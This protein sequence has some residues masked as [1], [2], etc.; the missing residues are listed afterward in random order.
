MRAADG[1]ESVNFAVD[2]DRTRPA[3]QLLARTVKRK[4]AG[5]KEN[6]L[7]T[8]YTVTKA[9]ET[10]KGEKFKRVC[11]LSFQF[12]CESTRAI[13]L[14]IG[15]WKALEWCHE[16]ALDVLKNIPLNYV[17]KIS[18][19][20]INIKFLWIMSCIKNKSLE[21]HTNKEKRINYCTSFLKFY[22]PQRISQETPII[23]L[24][25]WNIFL[26]KKCF[27]EQVDFSFKF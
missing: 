8:H 4:K 11:A 10:K 22:L 19:S 3:R 6:E 1:S 20:G 24:K 5:N 9:K 15:V 26:T 2:L 18:D 17:F 21:Y 25:R 14:S 23:F 13:F 27:S 7:D 12:C 16:V